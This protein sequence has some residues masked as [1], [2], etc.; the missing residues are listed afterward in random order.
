MTSTWQGMVLSSSASRSR[1]RHIGRQGH[2]CLDGDVYVAEVVSCASGAGAEKIDGGGI[3]AEH[4]EYD[5][6]NPFQ[7]GIVVAI[8]VAGRQIFSQV[9][10][11]TGKPQV[12]SLSYLTPPPPRPPP[13]RRSRRRPGSR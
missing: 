2:A 1:G 7:N 8:H 5:V 10:D 12:A 9:Y 3:G 13:A 6:S 4:L 11:S